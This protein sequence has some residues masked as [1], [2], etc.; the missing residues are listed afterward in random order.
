MKQKRNHKG[1]MV[2]K[3]HHSHQEQVMSTLSY[4]ITIITAEAPMLL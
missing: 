1:E 4:D 3:N 2:I